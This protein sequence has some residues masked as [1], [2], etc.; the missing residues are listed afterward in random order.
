MGLAVPGGTL[1]V[2][3]ASPSCD[4]WLGLLVDVEENR[5]GV[6][7]PEHTPRPAAPAPRGTAT[8]PGGTVMEAICAEPRCAVSLWLVADPEGRALRVFCGQ[9]RPPQRRA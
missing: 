4:R 3:C 8:D 1:V 9:H 2:P 5:L 7:C 6:L